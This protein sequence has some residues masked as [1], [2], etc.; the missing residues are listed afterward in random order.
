VDFLELGR[1]GYGAQPSDGVLDG[2]GDA[3]SRREVYDDALAL[4]RAGLPPFG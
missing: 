4:R 3:Q 2:E 1:A